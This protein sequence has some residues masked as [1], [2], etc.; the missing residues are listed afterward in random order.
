MEIEEPVLL[1]GIDVNQKVFEIGID[2][3]TDYPVEGDGIDYFYAGYS[4]IRITLKKARYGYPRNHYWLIRFVRMKLAGN[5]NFTFEHADES[6]ITICVLRPTEKLDLITISTAYDEQ[7]GQYIAIVAHI[8][9][10]ITGEKA[11]RLF[12]YGGKPPT[13]D[14]VN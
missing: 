13:P 1:I 3:S 8:T 14:V 6:D 5:N 9:N 10:S 11:T 12:G 2:R 4:D 7:I